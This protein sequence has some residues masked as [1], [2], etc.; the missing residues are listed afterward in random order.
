[1]GQ[2]IHTCLAIAW[3][4]KGGSYDLVHL[5]VG[6]EVASYAPVTQLAMVT[7]LAL[8]APFIYKSR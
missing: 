5:I 8:V 4:I 3:L 7:A 1:M 6:A 2:S